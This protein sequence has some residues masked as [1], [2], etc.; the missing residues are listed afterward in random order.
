MK[1]F[2]AAVRAPPSGHLY[3]LKNGRVIK[4]YLYRSDHL[5]KRNK[6]QRP[7]DQLIPS[8]FT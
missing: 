7:K 5:L 3:N 6:I 8:Y 2:D 4:S 1:T